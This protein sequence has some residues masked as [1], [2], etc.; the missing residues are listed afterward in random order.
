ML[1]QEPGAFKVYLGFLTYD[2]AGTNKVTDIQVMHSEKNLSEEVTLF[3]VTVFWE[4][5]VPESVMSQNSSC[6]PMAQATGDTDSETVTFCPQ[7]R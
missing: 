3:L 2:G 6:Q 1:G 7:T 4:M 5:A